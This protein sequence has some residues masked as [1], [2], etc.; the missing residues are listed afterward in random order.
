[1][2][3]R[4]SSASR[5]SMPRNSF[6]ALDSCNKEQQ[7][8]QQTTPPPTLSVL[9]TVSDVKV[10]HN[11]WCHQGESKATEIL[12]QYSDLFPKDKAYRKAVLEHKCPVCNLMK[13]AHKYR[14]SKR[15]KGKEAASK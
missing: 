8:P 12:D 2:L 13:G 7:M 9:W 1:M 4:S 5:H 14:K 10:S 15:Q 6:A 3:P 11:S